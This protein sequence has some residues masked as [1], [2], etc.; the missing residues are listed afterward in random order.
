MKVVAIKRVKESLRVWRNG[1]R[2][3]LKKR[4]PFGCEG[5]T[6]STRTNFMNDT[7]LSKTMALVIAFFVASVPLLLWI[8][9]VG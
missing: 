5:P 8:G 2:G 4:Y 9:K 3:A 7:K 1:I 6:P